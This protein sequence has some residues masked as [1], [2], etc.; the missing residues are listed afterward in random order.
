MTLDI[1]P[2]W[3]PKDKVCIV[4]HGQTEYTPWGQ[5]GRPEPQLALEA[6]I[7][8]VED[9]G[10]DMHDV[11]GICSNLDERSDPPS[12]AS[13]LGLPHMRFSHQY[14]GGG[15]GGGC[16][17]VMDAALAI[18]YGYA[19]YVVVYR[20]LSQNPFGRFSLPPGTKLPG[21]MPSNIL[22]SV[23]FSMPWGAFTPFHQYA[24]QARRHMH[25][26]GTE[27]RHFGMISVACNKHAQHNPAATMY[28]KPITL[29]EHQKSE[30][31]DDPIRRYDCALEN[32]GA[33][34]IVLTSVERA[35]D[36]KHR[37]VYITAA[38][39]GSGFRQTAGAYNKA[40]FDTA[41]FKKVAAELW[42]RAGITPKDID[43]AQIYENA[44]PMTLMSIEDH[45]FCKKGEGGPF[46]EGGRLEWP[47]GDLPLNTS[48]G[49]IAECYLHGFEL[50][51]EAVRQMRG[52]STCQVKEAEFCLVTGGPGISPVSDMI[53]RR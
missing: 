48:G 44:T 8:A 2:E 1:I 11:D 34:A 20:S 10:V 30:I 3:F 21:S 38:S 9:A 36:L 6:I 25:L 35:K 31:V 4:G 37:P 52:T 13:Y 22:G 28:G 40:D 23:A 45:G 42:A 47:N 16:G 26:Y 29:K 39:Q 7:K 27:S 43:V 53:V 46:V 51:I 41:N 12:L 18:A 15:G 5:I 24:L 33:V 19:N 50:I 49:N 14:W 32:D 17:C